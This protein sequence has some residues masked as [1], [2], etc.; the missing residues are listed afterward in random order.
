MPVP[1]IF[2]IDNKGEIVE[3]SDQPYDS[4]QLLQELLAQYP[5]VLAGDQ[6]SGSAPVKWLL[7]ARE[8]GIPGEE[9]GAERWSLDHVFID[10]NGIPTLVEVK[11][12]TDTRIR[13]EVVG[14]MLDYAANAVLYWPVETIRQ[15]FEQTCSERALE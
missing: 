5:S 12:S 1:T 9:G 13:R 11:R 8:A 2:L 10:Q 4:E 14:Q 15:R 7:V 3:M 6:M